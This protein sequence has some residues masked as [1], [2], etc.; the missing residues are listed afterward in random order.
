MELVR[1]VRPTGRQSTTNKY[2]DGSHWS[3]GYLRCDG[4][5]P[6]WMGSAWDVDAGTGRTAYDAEAGG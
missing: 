1:V 5:C 3:S 6:T 2:I 4:G